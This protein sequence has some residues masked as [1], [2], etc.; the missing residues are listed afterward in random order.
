MWSKVRGKNEWTFDVKARVRREFDVL[1]KRE[2]CSKQGEMILIFVK[3]RDQ[4]SE[5][6]ACAKRSD[7]IFAA[8]Q[9]GI[10]SVFRYE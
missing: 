9:D 7:D 6:W 8:C 1:F 10:L 3:T 4:Q 2:K 5:V